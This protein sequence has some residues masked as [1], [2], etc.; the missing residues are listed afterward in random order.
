M[1]K[2]E[3]FLSIKNY[4]EYDARREEFKDLDWTDRDLRK[5]WSSLMPKANEE[6][7]DGIIKE[8]FHKQLPSG[9]QNENG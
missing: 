2:R 5:H 6:Y 9:T 3:E 8:A 1:S 7:R 4:E